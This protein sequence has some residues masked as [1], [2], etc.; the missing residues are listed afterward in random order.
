M[1]PVKS[2]KHLYK[3][4]FVTFRKVNDYQNASD[5]CMSMGDLYLKSD[6]QENARNAFCCAV[7]LNPGNAVGHWKLG[8][9]MYN[10][11]HSDLAL[12]R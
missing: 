6:D 8:L 4:L 7:L 9:T 10:L 11:G 12:I 2:G 3:N 1:Y 5:T